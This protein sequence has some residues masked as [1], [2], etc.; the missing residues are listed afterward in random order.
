[1]VEMKPK[2]AI[3]VG[4]LELHLSP[5]LLTPCRS[6]LLLGSGNIWSTL[7]TPGQNDEV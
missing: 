1:M 5:K 3:L 6:C 7:F 2:I 4:L